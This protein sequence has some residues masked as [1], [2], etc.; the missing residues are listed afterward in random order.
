MIYSH[1]ALEKKW[2]EYWKN[3]QIFKTPSNMTT[4]KTYILDMFPYPSGAGLHVG[5]LKGYIATDVM[6]RFR[7][8]QG[9]AVLHPIGWDAF[10]LPA[11]QYALKTK[12][13]PVSFTLENINNFRHQLKLLGFSYDYNKEINTTDPN[14]YQWTQ[15]IFSQIY[16]KGLVQLKWSDVNWC[17]K[18]GTVLANEEVLVIEGKMVSERGHYSVIKKPMQ[19]WVLKITNYASRLLKGLDDLDWPN[20]VKELQRNWIGERLGAL[21]DFKIQNSLEKI[22][23]F[24]TRLDTIFGVSAIILAPEHPLVVLLT[25]K[26]N[27]QQMNEYLSEVKMKTDLE[28]QELNND[29]QG[30]FTG[31]YALHPLTNEL[32]PIW[33]ADYVLYHYG[34][35]AIMCVPAHS[36]EN[37]HLALKYNLPIKIVI[38]NN[39]MKMPI[40]GDGIHINSQFLNGLNNEQAISKIINVLEAKAIAKKHTT[41]KL[42]DWLFSRQ[43][44][45]GEPFPIIFWDDGTTSLVDELDLPV[46]LPLTDNIVSTVNGQSPLENMVDFVNVTRN[47][48][49]KGKRDTNTMPQWAGSCW[50]YLAYILKQDDGSFIPLNSKTAFKLLEQWLPVDLYV[51]GQEHAVLHLLYARFWHQVLYDLKVVPTPEPFMKLVNQG[52]ILGVDGEKMSKSKD[53]GV[54][55]DDIIMTHGADALRVY[56]MFMG[57]LTASMPWNIQGIDGTRRWLDRIYR[58]VTEHLAWI[59]KNNDG[60]MD[61]IYHQTVFKVTTDLENLAFNTAL[62]SLMVF[63]NAC[64]KTKQIY[65]PYFLGFIKMLSLFAVHLAEELWLILAQESSAAVQKWPEYDAKYLVKDEVVVIIQVNGKLRGKLNVVPNLSQEEIL[66]IIQNDDYLQKILYQ[67]EIKQTIFVMNKI[68]N[69]VTKVANKHDD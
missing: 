19:Q 37:Y 43:R 5:H 28:R 66:K 15:W 32:L 36:A 60:Q 11:E 53:N 35:G 24:T 8:M 34:T 38:E 18:L 67:Y 39:N 26:N 45:W 17:E 50:Y 27:E 59:I 30:V 46:M 49:V 57:P 62:S 44:Y 1:R 14:Y 7:K 21:V 69:F 41:Y 54:N 63:V 58:L 51:G 12:N 10:G 4:K 42:R 64:Y 29:K 9:Y 47:D 23:V 61:K 2:Q 65:L 20:S 6:A 13:N 3:Q 16:K 33:V 56:E 68:I 55:P 22:S 48:G 40:T 31:S 52:M 25:I